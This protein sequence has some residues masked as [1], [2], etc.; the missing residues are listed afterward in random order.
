MENNQKGIALITTLVLGLIALAFIGALLYLLTSGTKISGVEKRYYTALE[1]AKS[2]AELVISN[3]LSGDLKCNGTSCTPCPTAV[4]NACK[5]DLNPS[6][7]GSYSVESYLLEK[8]A[9]TDISGN[10]ISIYTIKVIAK[11][12]NK[13]EEKA[14]IEFVYKVR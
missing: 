6:N 7:L 13:P 14:E 1:A 10:S 4:S 5:I 11:N 9:F 2:G 3:I 8:E 12:F